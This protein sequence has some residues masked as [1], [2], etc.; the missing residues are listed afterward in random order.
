MWNHWHCFIFCKMPVGIALF[1]ARCTNGHYQSSL[2]ISKER[3]ASKQL[4]ETKSK[5]KPMPTKPTKPG[6]F[7]FPFLFCLHVRVLSPHRNAPSKYRH[8]KARLP[9]RW[10]NCIRH[11]VRYG[12]LS[13]IYLSWK[14][15]TIAI[16]YPLP[17]SAPAPRG[18]IIAPLVMATL[19]ITADANEKDP[20]TRP[21][22]SSHPEEGEREHFI[23]CVENILTIPPLTSSTPP[24]SWCHSGS[25]AE[26]TKR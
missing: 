9:L 18:G 4:G 23:F 6:L 3:I 24:A 2:F 12:K 17:H 11:K 13:I 14:Y 1:F 15:L 7:C 25:S 5:P 21:V 19:R 26:R 8:D 20:Q 10:P 16:A 22:I